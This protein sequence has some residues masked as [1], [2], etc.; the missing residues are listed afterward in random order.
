MLSRLDTLVVV[1]FLIALLWTSLGGDQRLAAADRPAGPLHKTRSAV[2]ARQGM[3]ATSQPL[4][5]AAAIRVLQQGGNAVDAAIAAN[6]VLGV[7]EPMSCGL[8]GD[9][10]AIVWEPEDQEAV[11]TQRQWPV[12]RGGHDL[13][14]SSQGPGPHSHARASELVGPRLRRRLGSALPQ[15]RHA[16]PVRGACAGH[17]LRRGGFPVSEIIAAD[18]K[19]PSAG[20]RPMP[21]S[22]ACFLP[23][24]HAPAAGTV[25]RNPGLAR[26]L[27]GRSPRAAATRFI[28]GRS[29][30]RSSP[31]RSRWAACSPRQ[32]FAEHTSTWVEPVS[33]NYRG[34][35]V[36]ELPPNG[37]GIAALQML[38][39]LEPYD[40]KSMGFGIGRGASSDDRGQETGLRGPGQVLRR[41]GEGQGSGTE[42]ISKAYAAKRRPLID[43]Q[44]ANL[45][46]TPGEPLQADTIY[47]TVVDK[48][49][50][51]V[52]LIQSNFHGF[53][54]YHVPGD[55]GFRA[56][57]PGMPV[58]ARRDAAEPPGAAQA[59]I[60]HDHPGVRHQGRQALAELRPDGGRHAGAG[61]CPGD[62]QPDRF[63]H[64]RAGGR[65]RCRG[66]ATSAP[67]S[68][69]ASRP[70]A[71]AWSRS[72]Q[73]SRPEVRQQLESH[74]PPSGRSRSRQLRR[75]PGH[76]HRPRTRRLD[77]RIR[78]AQGRRSDGILKQTFHAKTQRKTAK[79]Q[80][81]KLEREF[82]SI[83]DSLG[84]R[85]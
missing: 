17:R 72:S 10:F 60:P 5:T 64:G 1:P 40:L 31:I 20:S 21:T 69:P 54:S 41:H 30:G 39:L 53:G 27:A 65:R 71:A 74:G 24:G 43:P 85:T 16:N 81:R 42:L 56:S 37:Q 15:V 68:R 22:A 6:A 28:E 70:K 83:L 23:G 63:R 82:K 36:W 80:R 62:L 34:Y 47:L 55:L 45:H 46:P 50:N 75:L 33:T 9:L 2:M 14:I 76:P 61:P 59:A 66:F 18:W 25:F 78:P 84:L 3:A 67:R 7:V 8:G 38:N 48:D 51:C 32:D 77:R 29:P 73:R 58:R 79:T 52:S 11:R 57:E 13:A 12:S 4:A 44:R 35:D 19:G 26:S 49:F